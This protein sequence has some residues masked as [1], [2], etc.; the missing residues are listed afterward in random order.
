MATA[1]DKKAWK[2]ISHKD[3]SSKNCAY[4]NEQPE[5]NTR[6]YFVYRDEVYCVTPDGELFMM[7]PVEVPSIGYELVSTD[8]TKKVV[9][10]SSPG[11]PEHEALE[12]L[13]HDCRCR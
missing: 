12:K 2:N 11:F 4:Y 6:N 13:F 1:D 10:A 5:R 7:V 9:M 8:V 3:K